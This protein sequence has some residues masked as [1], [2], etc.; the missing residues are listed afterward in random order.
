MRIGTGDEVPGSIPASLSTS[1]GRNAARDEYVSKIK[2]SVTYDAPHKAFQVE[3]P[4]TDS[5]Q[6]HSRRCA[7][8]GVVG[9]FC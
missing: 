6:D 5:R 3:E 7:L 4:H 8:G 2:G 9:L 1:S